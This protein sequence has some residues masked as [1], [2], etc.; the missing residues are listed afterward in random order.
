MDS[1]KSSEVI[2]SFSALCRWPAERSIGLLPSKT[3]SDSESASESPLQNSSVTFN[4]NVQPG[5]LVAEPYSWKTVVTGQPILRLRTTGSKAAVMT[6]PPGRHLLKL[7]TNSS[8][9][10]HVHFLSATPFVFGDEDKI[11]NELVKESARFLN[12]SQLLAKALGKCLTSFTDMDKLKEAGDEFVGIHCPY[13]NDKN[14]KIKRHFSIWN[15]ALFLT[16]QKFLKE[17][18]SNYRT[19]EMAFAW[20]VLTQDCTSTNILGQ[21]L[22]HSR[23]GKIEIN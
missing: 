17:D 5:L 21:D 22:S 8:L 12:S 14:S 10:Y 19:P 6:L 18:S 13:L 4:E 20:R 3:K 9:G 1:L 11:M 7:H 16:V 2:A 15:E 23:P